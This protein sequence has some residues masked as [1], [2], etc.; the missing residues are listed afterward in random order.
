MSPK[1]VKYL[2]IPKGGPSHRYHQRH[3]PAAQSKGGELHSDTSNSDTFRSTESGYGDLGE[4]QTQ[5][6]ATQDTSVAYRI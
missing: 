5:C 6:L 4:E 3:T 2:H 1:T